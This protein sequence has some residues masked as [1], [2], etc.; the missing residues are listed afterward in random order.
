MKKL[1]NLKENFHIAS[2]GELIN[3]ACFVVSVVLGVIAFF[4]PPKGQIDNSVLMFIAEVGVFSTISR[5]P[6]FIK[7]VRDSHTNLEIKR[8]ETSIKIEGDND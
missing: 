4:L 3:F 6:D 2:I 7:S 8:G 5:V 1:S